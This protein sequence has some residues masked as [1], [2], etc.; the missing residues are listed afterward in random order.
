[1]PATI[2]IPPYFVPEMNLAA[3]D[4]MK[5]LR[6]FSPPITRAWTGLAQRIN[7]LQHTGGGA[8]RVLLAV[9]LHVPK[10]VP[11]VTFVE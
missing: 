9:L 8:E 4:G 7:E 1:M 10:L 6:P 2:A 3:V 5:L 11:P